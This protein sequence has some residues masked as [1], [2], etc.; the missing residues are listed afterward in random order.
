MNYDA[1]VLFLVSIVSLIDDA[2]CYVLRL[3][4]V[5]VV[6][7]LSVYLSS[8]VYTLVRYTTL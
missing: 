1:V 8:I 3:L 6:V 5:L 2:M 7:S 4:V